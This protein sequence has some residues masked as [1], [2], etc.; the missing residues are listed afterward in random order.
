[1]AS[2][3]DDEVEFYDFI[4]KEGLSLCGDC[5]RQELFEDFKIGG[6]KFEQM[7]SQILKKFPTREAA[8]QAFKEE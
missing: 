2:W 8:M 3:V 6:D 1:M 7:K 5:I 4:W